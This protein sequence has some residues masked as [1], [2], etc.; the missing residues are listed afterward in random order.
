MGQIPQI[1]GS[2]FQEQSS[3]CYCLGCGA[4]QNTLDTSQTHRRKSYLLGGH[5]CSRWPRLRKCPGIDVLYQK[6]GYSQH[7]NRQSELQ[8]F[9]CW[10][11]WCQYLPRESF[12]NALDK[13]LLGVVW[14]QSAVRWKTGTSESFLIFVVLSCTNLSIC[15]Y[16]CELGML[17]LPREMFIRSDK[18]LVCWSCFTVTMVQGDQGQA[19]HFKPF[20][21]PFS[22]F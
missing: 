19:A 14:V 11:N 2:L 3:Y 5:N 18:I 22:Q 21:P 13:H 17:C 4:V 12:E 16:I 6:S 9:W 8:V 10:N 15:R 7:D 1:S 20:F